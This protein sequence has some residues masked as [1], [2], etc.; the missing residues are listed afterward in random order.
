MPCNSQSSPHELPS[1]TPSC[2]ASM[3][4]E[5]GTSMFENT[6]SNLTDHSF[7]ASELS[8]QSHSLLQPLQCSLTSAHHYLTHSKSTP[9]TQLWKCCFQLQLKLNLFFICEV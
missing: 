4:A 7:S 6:L 5:K 3:E 9:C 2:Q 1:Y 8:P